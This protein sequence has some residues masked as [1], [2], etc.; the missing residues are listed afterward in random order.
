MNLKRRESYYVTLLIL[1]RL[2]TDYP[3]LHFPTGINKINIVLNILSRVAP[4]I[5]NSLCNFNINL[6]ES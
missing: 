2:I 1:S 6:Q 4:Y 5:R 3:I